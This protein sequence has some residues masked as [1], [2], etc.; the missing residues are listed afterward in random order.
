MSRLAFVRLDSAAEGSGRFDFGLFALHERFD[1]VFDVAG[2]RSVLLIV[3]GALVSQFAF[4]IEDKDVGG[5][6]SAKGAG[7]VTGLIVGVRIID[8]F[9]LHALLHGLKVLRGVDVDR[10]ELDVLASKFLLEIDE[11]VFVGDRYRASIAGKGD[12]GGFGPF[13]IG[14]GDVLAIDPLGFEIRSFGS[15]FEFSGIGATEHIHRGE[16]QGEGGGRE[17]TQT[18][19]AI[20]SGEPF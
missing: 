16:P 19:S 8:S 15:D 14:K 12:D 7:R 20:H 3:E 10:N 18:K 5:H 17:K 1:G 13:A 6:A 4:A 2:R 11:S 9:F